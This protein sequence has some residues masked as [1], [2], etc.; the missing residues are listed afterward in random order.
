MLYTFQF[1]FHTEC[2]LS[3]FIRY[4]LVIIRKISWFSQLTDRTI[5]PRYLYWCTCSIGFLLKYTLKG[6]L[7]PKHIT[8]VLIS[9]TKILFLEQNFNRPF[10][11]FWRPAA[12]SESRTRSS[13]HKMWAIISFDITMPYSLD[14]YVLKSD[15]YFRNINPLAIPPWLTPNLLSIGALSIPLHL[16][17]KCVLP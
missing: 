6:F 16:T 1:L 17:R 5:T 10:S 8:L 7:V 4:D 3:R 9:L 15:M 13:A 2:G 11:C 14:K 12:L